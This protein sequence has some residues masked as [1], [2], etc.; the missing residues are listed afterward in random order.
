[1][2][3]TDAEL[4]LIKSIKE[5]QQILRQEAND[6]FNTVDTRF[7][8]VDTKFDSIHTPPDCPNIREIRTEI[9]KS[10]SDRDIKLTRNSDKI[11][12]V[13]DQQ[14]RWKYGFIGIA[15]FLSILITFRDAIWAFIKSIKGIMV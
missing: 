15:A 10:L 14:K 1:M 12:K 5:G 9:D 8:T 7:N 13:I 3:L 6:R 4:E 11:D 2:T